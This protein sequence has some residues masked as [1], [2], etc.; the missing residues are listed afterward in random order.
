L[1][2]NNIMVVKMKIIKSIT[3]RVKLKYNLI[4]SLVQDNIRFIR[5]SFGGRL[6]KPSFNELEARITKAYHSIE[7]GLAYDKIRLGFGENVLKELN[8]LLET[9]EKLGFPLDAHCY[10][11]AIDNL[12]KYLEMHKSKDFDIPGLKHRADNKAKLNDLG[13]VASL[14]KSRVLSELKLPF[15][16]F[17]MSRH[18]VREFSDEPVEM[19]SILSAIKL[20]TKTPS[21]CNRQSWKT[22]IIVDP[23]LKKLV[24]QNQNGNRGFG[25]RID[26]YLLIT[27]D[28]RYF[29]KPRE[30]NQQYIDG[31]LYAM[32]LLLSLHF[33]GIATI[34][35]SASL[36]T[37][38]EKNLRSGLG[39]KEYEN[40]VMFIGVG[41]YPETLKVPKSSRRDPVVEILE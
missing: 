2:E 35:L 15:N 25:E 27:T 8:R 29:A 34:S 1:Y 38:Q 10:Q 16:D 40:F 24:E 5:F 41:N 32:S 31:G 33:E 7:K 22:R 12:S 39:I 14:D 17:F 4:S 28:T 30:R 36:T 21:A 11:T 3:S 37:K 9:Y 26:K 20:A 23:S 13:G 19:N 6:R 18:S